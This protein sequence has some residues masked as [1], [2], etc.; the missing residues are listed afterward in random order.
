MKKFKPYLVFKVFSYFWLSIV[1]TIIILLLISSLSFVD[2]VDE[3]LSRF[4]V[5][6]L[7]KKALFLSKVTNRTPNAKVLDRLIHPS[8]KRKILYLKGPTA[9]QSVFSRPLPED[10]DVNLLNYVESDKPRYILTQHFHAAGPIPINIGNSEYWLYELKLTREPPL[11]IKLKLLPIWVK[12]VV[13]VLMSLFFA[14]LFSRSIVSPIK[15]LRDSADDIGKGRLSSRVSQ[16]LERT[17]ELGE[18]IYDFNKMAEQLESLMGGQKRLLADISHELRSP[19]TRLSLAAGLA[20]DSDESKKVGYLN[21]IEKEAQTLDEM[22]G[23]VLML[24]RLENQQQYLQKEDISI[25]DLMTPTLQDAEFEASSVDKQL[26]VEALPLESVYVDKKVVVS[27][28]DNI[29]RNAIRYANS[30]VRVKVEAKNQQIHIVIVDDGPGVPNHLL[31]KLSDPFYRHSESR[32]RSS[33][34]A[35][36]GLAIA[37]KA[38]LAHEGKLHIQNN[39]DQGLSVTLTLKKADA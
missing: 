5:R 17:D 27:A 23:S 9:E 21:R 35:G 24:S 14:W 28:I 32:T 34:G 38:M 36:L 26:L 25:S 39:D 15:A 12:L 18:L 30:C 37:Q 8:S 13:P 33:G 22:I 10:V 6:D 3:P 2:A 1:A 19:L 31:N 20:K 11:F 4:K 7:Q 16:H 29:L